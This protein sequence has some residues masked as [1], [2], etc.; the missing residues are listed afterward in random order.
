M[1]SVQLSREIRARLFIASMLGLS[2]LVLFAANRA[3]ERVRRG[4]GVSTPQLQ[5]VTREVE[6]V[7]DT[8]FVRH[9]IE[10]TWVKTWRVQTPDKRTIRIEKRVFVPPEFVSV[11]FNQELNRLIMQYGARAVALEHLEESTVTMHII[12]DHMII[13][14]VSFVVRRD[15]RPTD[16]GPDG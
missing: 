6:T 9:G 15:L 10:Q 4:S 2:A 3:T 12:H 13:E 11:V 14:S 7:L 5:G 8:L 16:G 1:T